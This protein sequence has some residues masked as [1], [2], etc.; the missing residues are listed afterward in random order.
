MVRIIMNATLKVYSHGD[1]VPEHNTN[2]P[3][4]QQSVADVE[5]KERS[6]A[7]RSRGFNLFDRK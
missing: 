4:D 5:W 7:I 6:H 2:G 3:G 1:R